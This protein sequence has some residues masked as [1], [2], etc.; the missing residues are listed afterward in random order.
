MNNAARWVVRN[1]YPLFWTAWV[2][3]GVIADVNAVRQGKFQ[4]TLTHNSRRITFQHP[5]RPPVQRH[6]GRVLV[7]AAVLWTFNHIALGP[8]HDSKL[9]RFVVDRVLCRNG[10]TCNG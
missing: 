3:A 6:A 9:H 8:H 2:A 1:R 5:T 7:G 10:G 4:D